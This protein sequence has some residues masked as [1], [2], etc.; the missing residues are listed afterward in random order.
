MKFN[1]KSRGQNLSLSKLTN[2]WADLSLGM[3]LALGLALWMLPMTAASA[4]VIKLD[5]AFDPKAAE[6]EA[7]RKDEVVLPMPCGGAMVFKKVYTG[8]HKQV[9]DRHFKVG[10]SEE[11]DSLSAA[12]FDRYVQGSFH[13][14]DGYYYLLA[15]YELTTAQARLLQ[16]YD[17][18]KG[19][20]EGKQSYGIKDRLAQGDLS[21][22]AAIDLT[23][24]YSHY[25][26]SMQAKKDAQALGVS[27]PMADDGKTVAFVRLPTDSEWEFAAR[28]GT[29]VSSSVFN[30]DFFA[31]EGDGE[32]KADYVWYK[33]NE[34]SSD[35][36][37]NAIGLK[38][39][40][41]LGFYDI[42][43]NV[44]E[45]MLDPF[46]ITR[47]GRLHGCPG[48][49]IV[50]GGSVLSSQ[51][52]IATSL[53]IEKDFYRQGQ[54]GKSRDV[55]VR[56]ALSLPATTS[57]QSLRQLRAEL[58]KL[59]AEDVND[60]KGGGDLRTVEYLD[61]IIE[62]Q[63][64]TYEKEKSDLNRNNQS[65]SAANK[66]LSSAITS[67]NARLRELRQNMVNVN[68][69]RDEMRDRAIVS[70]LRLGGYLCSS[71]A[72]AQGDLE[73]RLNNNEIV[74]R[75]PLSECR[76]N[77]M[78]DKCQNA[79]ADQE[80]KLEKKKMLAAKTLD[81]YAS[82]YADH[83]ADITNTFEINFVLSQQ[84]AAKRSLGNKKSAVPNYIERFVKDVQ[85]YA[86][87]SRN[88]KENKNR[89]IKQC[90]TVVKN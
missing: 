12:P 37:V 75:M 30:A 56:F 1:Y 20:C 21:W 83:I 2:L 53:R 22:F 10:S 62:E 33:G 25:L 23:R 5:V 51:A 82:Y 26:S 85:S 86:N 50:R 72:S 55:G 76:N 46:Y 63:Q 88:L 43:G 49:Y 41:P 15:K 18:G 64:K 32:F 45:I 57:I 7:E 67:L 11:S 79:I 4:A 70:A 61:K 68:T 31:S 81:F 35:G 36:R 42:L 89:W 34:S 60:A 73:W 90:S 66:E 27:L 48:G 69:K 24:Q 19:K 52:E 47:T 78:S 54:E 74:R 77:R 80:E 9:E 28:G 14:Q 65:L 38:K 59:G 29:K 13:D 8:T 58:K 44:S 17:L 3:S 87:G 71:L 16:N 39:P 6:T 84:E 40:N